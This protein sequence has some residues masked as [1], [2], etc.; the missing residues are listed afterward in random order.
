LGAFVHQ[1]LEALMRALQGFFGILPREISCNIQIARRIWVPALSFSPTAR[2]T[3]NLLLALHQELVDIHSM[4]AK[5]PR[6]R[7]IRA[8][9]SRLGGE[10]LPE[11]RMVQLAGFVA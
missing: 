8:Q 9:E 5:V 10:Y 1:S 3:K 11:L 4:S 6:H 2:T 7:R